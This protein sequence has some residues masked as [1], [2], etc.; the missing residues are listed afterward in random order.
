MAAS[1][2]YFYNLLRN[3]ILFKLDQRNLN[4]LFLYCFFLTYFIFSHNF[5]FQNVDREQGEN[6]LTGVTIRGE[7]ASIEQA[8]NYIQDLVAVK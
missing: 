4:D 3:F 6:G 2:A 8:K 5:F 1:F 7:E